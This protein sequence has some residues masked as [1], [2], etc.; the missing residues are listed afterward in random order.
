MKKLKNVMNRFWHRTKPT[1]RLLKHNFYSQISTTGG[2]YI[3]I[4]SHNN[5]GKDFI[6]QTLYLSLG[7]V[8]ESEEQCVSLLQ[9]NKTDSEL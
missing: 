8:E 9:K 4:H 3:L 6:G 2:I 1:L 7:M 5:T